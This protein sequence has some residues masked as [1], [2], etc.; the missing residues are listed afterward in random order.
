MVDPCCPP[1]PVDLINLFMTAYVDQSNRLLADDQFDGDPV[2]DI[3]GNAV[4]TFEFAFERM[5]TE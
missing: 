2:A 4:Q 3:D 5:Q 1:L